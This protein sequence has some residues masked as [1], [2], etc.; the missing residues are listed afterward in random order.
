M[1]E[2]TQNTVRAGPA[3]WSY[4]DWKGIVYPERMPRSLHPLELLSE[5]FDAIEVN[6]TFYRPANPRWCESWMKKVAKNPQFRFS[7]KLQQEFTHERQQWPDDATVARFCDG[8]RPLKDAGMLGA[9][10]AQFPWSF[11]RTVDNRKWLAR[12]VEAFAGWPLVF[13]LRHMSWEC[14]EFFEELSQR[15]LAFCNI[16][17][18]LFDGS[19][20][21]TAY[22]TAPPGYVRF[23]GRN[24]ETWF[25]DNAGRDQRYDYLY[26]EDELAPWV[27][28]IN[29]M[30]NRVNDLF[31]IT[32]NHY[33]GQAVV[34]AL[35]I[36][37]AIGHAR[38]TLPGHLVDA[39]PRLKRLLRE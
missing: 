25:N 10:L 21:P 26:N 31:V 12:L 30:K 16:D 1:A 32:N 14:P 4:D 24:Y 2:E 6:A 15:N 9:L 17:Q 34:N 37:A 28:R 20:A 33:R 3:G 8:L 7:A 36:Q 19:I 18:P 39:Y 23:H 27:D 35:E 29:A 13:E 38:Y 22:V 11:K 5:W